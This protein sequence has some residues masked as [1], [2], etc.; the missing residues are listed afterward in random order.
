MCLTTLSVALNGSVP[1]SM[2]ITDVDSCSLK[3]LKLKVA[4]EQ[5]EAKNEHGQHH[6]MVVTPG[7]LV[8]DSSATTSKG[9][10]KVK[11]QREFDDNRME[12]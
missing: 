7:A 11:V 6:H 3:V 1:I 5:K 8:R 12:E 2:T 9:N 10:V 4:K